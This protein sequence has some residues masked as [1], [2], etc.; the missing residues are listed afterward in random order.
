MNPSPDLHNRAASLQSCEKIT[1]PNR[2]E[3]NTKSLGQK[4]ITAR[5]ENFTKK[6]SGPHT[7][8][9]VIPYLSLAI[10]LAFFA[11][12]F[13]IEDRLLRL[14]VYFI[15]VIIFIEMSIRTKFFLINNFIL[16]R[17]ILII[18]IL[19]MVIVK[20][21]ERVNEGI[22]VILTLF[23]FSVAFRSPNLT[24]EF[25]L[26]AFAL[27]FIHTIFVHGISFSDLLPTLYSRRVESESILGLITPLATISVF[28][29]RKFAWTLLGIFLT[30]AFYKRIALFGLCAVFFLDFIRYSFPKKLQIPSGYQ[31]ILYMSLIFTIFMIGIKFNIFLESLLNLWY[32]LTGYRLDPHQIS[33]GRYGAIMEFQNFLREEQN[34]WSLLF[35]HGPGYSSTFFML[36]VSS[37][38]SFTHVHNDYVRIFSDYGLLGV[39]FIFLF[40][41]RSFS[42]GRLS[43]ALSLYVAIVFLTDNTSIYFVF[44]LPYVLILNS[45]NNLR[46]PSMA[47]TNRAGG[48]QY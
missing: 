21:N 48:N 41:I 17:F 39:A 3:S 38:T 16:I 4:L 33:S 9:G 40:F 6:I 10:S 15:P 35:G 27:N 44:W 36:H 11:I 23:M 26:I 31:K 13:L 46:L 45:D 42:L 32:N 5:K 2:V 43:G 30:I 8:D 1:P 14:F 34:L 18:F 7:N 37:Q 47:A 19:L 12:F 29:R 25:F 20:P 28:I 22:F 24:A